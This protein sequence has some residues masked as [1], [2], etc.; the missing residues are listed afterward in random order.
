MWNIWMSLQKVFDLTHNS[1]R[2]GA[3]LAPGTKMK[4]LPVPIISKTSWKSM[5]KWMVFSLFSSLNLYYSN[6]GSRLYPR[7][8]SIWPRGGSTRCSPKGRSLVAPASRQIKWHHI[9]SNLIDKS[10][11]K[12][13]ILWSRCDELTFFLHFLVEVVDVHG[14]IRSGLHVESSLMSII[15]W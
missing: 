9:D 3:F 6:K 12:H 15:S 5:A 8:P 7:L 2:W 14:V 1:N 10:C 4:F 13:L 11:H